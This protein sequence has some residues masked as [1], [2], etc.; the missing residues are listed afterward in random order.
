MYHVI[1]EMASL[2]LA[3]IL[4]GEEFVVRY[5]VH[6]SMAV[7]DE[8]SH[9]K[10]RQALILRLRVLV[11]AIILP[12]IVL[13]VVVLVWGGSNGPVFGFQCAGVISLLF[14]LLITLVGTVPINKG[15]LDW[16]PDAPPNNWKMLVN[17]WG[18]IDIIRSTA[19][20]LAFVFFLIEV[21]LQLAGN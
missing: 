6:V 9:I 18:R 3:G 7:L 19:A 17:R 12:T 5:G 2:F 14:L 10:A 13:G 15:A 20:I 4:A 11:P 8:S 1:I 21:A 16:R